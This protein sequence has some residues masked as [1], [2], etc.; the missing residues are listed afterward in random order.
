MKIFYDGAEL[1]D[2]QK[3]QAKGMVKG[4][5]TNLTFIAEKSISANIPVIDLY[6]SFQQYCDGLGLPLSIQTSKNTCSEI[7]EEAQMYNN[8]YANRSNKL[9]IKIPLNFAYLDAIETLTKAG[10]LVNA[11]AVCNLNQAIVAAHSGAK[12]ISLFWG[13]MTDEGSDAMETTRQLRELIDQHNIDTEIL[14]G[15]IRTPADIYRAFTSGADIV[16]M[17]KQYF[18]KISNSLKGQE[19]EDLFFEAWDKLKP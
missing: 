16:T 18:E 2:A 10:F 12:I 19:A 3:F 4:V 17:P 7:V 11:T 1:S 9:Y 5:T 14:V 8:R 15:S 13:K 6:D